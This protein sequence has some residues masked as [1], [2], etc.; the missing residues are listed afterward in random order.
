MKKEI[1]LWI[2]SG[3]ELFE[4]TNQCIIKQLIRY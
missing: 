1:S 2:E 3:L 4:R